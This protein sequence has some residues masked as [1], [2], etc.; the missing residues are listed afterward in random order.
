L[1]S[2]RSDCEGGLAWRS[3]APDVWVK[4]RVE[5]RR[6]WRHTAFGTSEN[7]C[8]TVQSVGTKLAEPVLNP[9]PYAV[10]SATPDFQEEE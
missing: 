2:L 5:R 7:S 1:P 8:A 4:A 3:A 9:K 10:P 6:Y